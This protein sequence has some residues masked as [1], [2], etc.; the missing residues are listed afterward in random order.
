MSFA[1]SGRPSPEGPE[2]DRARAD[3][4][5]F[6]ERWIAAGL[7]TT[8]WSEEDRQQVV[9]GIRLLYRAQRVPWPDHVVWVKSPHELAAR[10]ESPDSLIA[11]WL[12]HPERR[13]AVRKA[14]RRR[15]IRRVR[16]ALSAVFSAAGIAYPDYRDR[17]EYEEAF[18]PADLPWNLLQGTGNHKDSIPEDTYQIDRTVSTALSDVWNPIWRGFYDFKFTRTTLTSLGW[19]GQ[20]WQTG[21]EELSLGDRERDL[22]KGLTMAH[23]AAGW[24]A[25]RSLTLIC[26]PPLELHSEQVTDLYRLHNAAGPAV[27]WADTPDI[28]EYYLHGVRMP[29]Q[30]C[31]EDVS[32]QDLRGERDDIVR[33]M[34]IA[35]MGWLRCVEDLGLPL[36]AA[37]GPRL[38]ND[39]AELRLFDLLEVLAVPAQLLLTVVNPGRPGRERYYGNVVPAGLHDPINAAAWQ[40]GCSVNAYRRF[41]AADRGDLLVLPTKPTRVLP[42]EPWRNLPPT[43]V[44]LGNQATVCGSWWLC[45]GD[46]SPGVHWAQGDHGDV[47][48]LGWL[49]VPRGQSAYLISGDQAASR[50]EP[51]RSRIAPGWYAVRQKRL[52]RAE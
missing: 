33:F 34:A 9:D 8:E 15:T 45:P 30:L 47:A 42:Q 38:V 11:S 49:Y 4:E 37:T 32:V 17:M 23:R 36:V 22:V 41:G 46:A 44:E 13:A 20:I 27:V 48:L 18:T 5:R 52:F 16:S 50:D 19:L 7:A 2:A 10:S 28:R 40:Y 12:E 43:G 26:E 35:Q 29:E 25:Y 14:R 31:Q 51:A 21:Y 39:R 3:A 24:S 6:T 1:P